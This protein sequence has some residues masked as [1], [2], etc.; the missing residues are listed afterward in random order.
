[1][2][3]QVKQSETHRVSSNT[4]SYQLACEKSPNKQQIDLWLNEG[5]SQRWISEQLKEIGDY[6]SVNSIAKYKK[7]RDEQI[8][9]EL[10]EDPVYQA[11]V[12]EVNEQL[13]ESIA[14]IKKVD[15]LGELAG[16]IDHSAELLAEARDNDIQIRS[17]KDLRMVQQTMLE[18]I[19]AYGDTMLK[20]Q[21]FRAIEDDPSILQNKNTTININV[22]SALA[23]ILTE[24]MKKGGD[25]YGLIDTLRNGIGQ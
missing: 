10:M 2:A 12:Y 13:N 8:Q 21:Q 22:K 19:Q 17:V 16:I 3:N 9:Q 20:A 24:A 23:E 6:I 25:G 4:G 7:Y 5:K 15:M 18:A 11:K 1:M 14:K